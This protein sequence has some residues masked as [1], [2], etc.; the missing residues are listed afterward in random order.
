MLLQTQNK[1][2]LYDLHV[3]NMVCSVSLNMFHGHAAPFLQELTGF[4]VTPNAIL[5][6]NSG[7][8]PDITEIYR[9]HCSS[10]LIF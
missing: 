4:Y 8:N 6:A 2:N 10:A 9:E 1:I 7:A 5:P 3:I